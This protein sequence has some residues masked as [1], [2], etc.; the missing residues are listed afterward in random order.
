M[1]RFS[2]RLRDLRLEKGYKQDEIA[3]KLNVTTSAYGYYEQGRNEPSLETVKIIS[4]T[5]QVSTD[6]L[7][8]LIDTPNSPNHFHL[9]EELSLE[10]SEL[11]T[12]KKM[13]ELHLLKEISS[14]PDTNVNMLYNYW[15]FIKKELDLKR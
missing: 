13:K 5:F 2:E 7:L 8:G 14:D 3:K 11:I 4:Q 9:S 10:G 1:Y 15:E 6:Y 12:I